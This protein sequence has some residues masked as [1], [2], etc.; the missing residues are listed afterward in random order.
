MVKGGPLTSGELPIFLLDEDV[1][2]ACSIC[3]N[4]TQFLEQG[5][6]QLHWC[7][8]EDCDLIFVAEDEDD[9]V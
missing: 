3:G 1:P 5:K 8:N 2:V 7:L 6:R 4:R 9:E